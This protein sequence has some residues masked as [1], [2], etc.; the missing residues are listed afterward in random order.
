MKLLVT[1]CSGFL[2]RYVM[3]AAVRSGHYVRALV[4]PA[5]RGLSSSWSDHPQV[6]VVRGDLRSRH[7]LAEMVEGVDAVVHLAAAK[8]GDLYEQFAGTVLATEHLLA[9]MDAVGVRRL[10]VTS[11]FSVYE[12]LR[13]W[14]WSVLDESSPLAYEPQSRDEYCQT[15]L[16]QERVV[17]EWFETGNLDEPK[18]LVILRPGAIF[19]REDLW[20]GRLGT[21][22]SDESCIRTG[23]LARVPLSY[24]ENC[25]D[26]VVV[27]AEH[28]GSDGLTVLNIVDDEPPSQRTYLNAL[29]KCT[30]APR[31]VI[32]VP[33][34]VVRSL[35]RLTWLTNRIVF[36]GRARVPGLFVPAL[37]HAR[38][39]PLRYTNAKAKSVLGWRPRYSW[40]EGLERACGNDD[41]L[42]L[43]PVEVRMK[44]SAPEP[45]PWEVAS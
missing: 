17:R 32:P 43:P 6:E 36:G 19:G 33:W 2:G 40:R 34:I 41:L 25:A 3:A 31:R 5:S 1:G 39:K 20:T 28:R 13:R 24:V 7:G 29:R 8:K 21:R 30:G 44:T 45:K 35:A 38:C 12:Y 22:L 26:A 9:A 11:S 10:V 16:V 18:R 14:S 23:A 37:L 27:A 4:R 42:K 15:K